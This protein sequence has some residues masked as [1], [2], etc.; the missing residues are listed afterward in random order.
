M[1]LIITDFGKT[2]TGETISLYHLE[3]NSGAYVEITDIGARLVK[4]VVPD[5]DGNL[6]DVI[7]GLSSG[8][9]YAND[10]CYYGAICGR[11]ANRI[12]DG[13]FILNDKEY[14]LNLNNGSNHLHGGFKNYSHK[15]WNA[16]LKDDKLVMTIESADG[17]E[18][19]PGN[20]T[21]TVTYGWSEDN[22]LSI[23]YEATCDQDTI[24]NFTSHGYFNLNGE[25]SSSILNHE[26]FIDADT[27]TELNDTQIP[28]GELLPV[29]GT[30]F[31]FR[32]LH[33]VGKFIDSDYPQLAKFGT[34]DHNFVINGDGLREAAVLQSKESGIRM[35]CFTDQ[36]GLQI[37][38]A[39]DSSP[40]A[41]KY[42]EAY[43]AWSSI[44]METQHYPDSIN[45]ENFPSVVLKANDSFRSKT[46]Y[47]FST[48]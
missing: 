11:Y 36:P 44:C 18:N 37:F 33:A 19:Y 20:L 14:Q 39:S 41:G 7:L 43:P 26:L 29:D 27:I 48:F 25:G 42:G 28:T 3:N 10:T 24:V 38:V 8:N 47:H 16:Q 34:Y 2:N 1:K 40:M 22:E 35:T 5:K 6:T 45:H 4:L 32:T 30:P 23:L 46:L 31:D 17:D 12:K 9:L 21:L 13:R 15:M